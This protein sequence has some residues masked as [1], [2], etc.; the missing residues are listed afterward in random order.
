MG[1]YMWF[2][3][4]LGGGVFKFTPI[5]CKRDHACQAE[6]CENTCDWYFWLVA[7]LLNVEDVLSV[8]AQSNLCFRLADLIIAR[9]MDRLMT[10]GIFCRCCFFLV[11]V[12]N[13]KRRKT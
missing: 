8:E 12:K 7:R 10:S 9:L 6:L 1:C 5:R 13:V 2:F 3:P 4:S 11:D